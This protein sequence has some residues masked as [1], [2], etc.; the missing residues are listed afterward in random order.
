MKTCTLDGCEL[1]HLAKGLCRKH[2]NEQDPKR[3]AKVP[4]V[5]DCCGVVTEKHPTNRYGARYC[6]YLCRDFTKFGPLSCRLPVKREPKRKLQTWQRQC[7]WCGE[8]FVTRRGYQIHCTKR[9][10]HKAGK[11]RRRAREAGAGGTYTW[12]EVIGLFLMFDRRC[13]YCEQPIV[14]QPDPDHVV[15]LSR[16][17]SNSLTNIL[18]CCQ[19]CNSDKRDL[20][21][22][23]WAEDRTRRGVEP[24]ATTW[25]RNDKRYRHLTCEIQAA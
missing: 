23:E 16:G 15:A 22:S 8:A 2:Y 1:K 10:S 11:A 24:R 20:T 12:A 14:G 13:A 3:H 18:P 5:C 4:V 21:L 25:D 7:A 17:G 9:C 19:L 6:S